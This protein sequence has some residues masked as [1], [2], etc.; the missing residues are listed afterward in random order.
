MLQ[1]CESTSGFLQTEMSASSESDSEV[2]FGSR[3]LPRTRRGLAKQHASDSQSSVDVSPSSENSIYT[4][5]VFRL[6]SLAAK[7]VQ[8]KG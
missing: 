3:C 5:Q 6:N 2:T 1:R 8:H 4:N 7:R